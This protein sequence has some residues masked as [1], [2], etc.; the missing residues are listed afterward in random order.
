MN[1]FSIH[2]CIINLDS[3][4]YI[5]NKGVC[6]GGTYEATVYFHGGF[7]KNFYFDNNNNLSEF[8]KNIKISMAE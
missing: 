2:N 8:I 1:I 7:H 6:S 5:E 3:I 4:T